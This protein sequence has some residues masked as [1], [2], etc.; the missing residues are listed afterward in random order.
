MEGNP[1]TLLPA[2]VTNLTQLRELGVDPG[3]PLLEGSVW[4]RKGNNALRAALAEHV[5][6]G[7]RLNAEY[8]LSLF[9]LFGGRGVASR[10]TAAPVEGVA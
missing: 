9:V 7:T 3:L 4:P 10:I 8:G 1:L 2:T 6:I 5:A